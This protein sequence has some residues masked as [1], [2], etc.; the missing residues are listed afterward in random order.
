MEELQR[1]I[2][3][4]G[5]FGLKE[6][7]IRRRNRTWRYSSTIRF[8]WSTAFAR[9]IGVICSPTQRMKT[10]FVRCSALLVE[11]TKNRPDFQISMWENLLQREAQKLTPQRFSDSR[12]ELRCHRN[13]LSTRQPSQFHACGRPQL[14]PCRLWAIPWPEG[15]DNHSIK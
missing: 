11:K 7:W 10:N 6:K 8:L 14:H 15:N 1:I 13:A 9:A 5:E 3:I 4:K 2:I 12:T